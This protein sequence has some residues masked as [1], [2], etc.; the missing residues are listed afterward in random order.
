[1]END[2]IPNVETEEPD[3]HLEDDQVLVYTQKIRRS[4][5]KSLLAQ[6]D[7]PA[8]D[9]DRTLLFSVLNDMDRSALTNKRIKTDS[10]SS[11][12]M[13]GSAAVIANLLQNIKVNDAVYT[14]VVPAGFRAPK[15]GDD[16]ELP[17]VSKTELNQGTSTVTFEDFEKIHFQLPELK[18]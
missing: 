4:G 1:M 13:A 9:K 2:E 18:D 5:V 17:P 16:V 10:E 14:G 8:A 15:I 6:G 12:N 7:L 3:S 11:K